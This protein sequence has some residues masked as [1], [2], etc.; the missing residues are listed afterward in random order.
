MHL[1]VFLVFFTCVTVMI[2]ITYIIITIIG[3]MRVH[4]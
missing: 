2:T 3:S 1:Y 4:H